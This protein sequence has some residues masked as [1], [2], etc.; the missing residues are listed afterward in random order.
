MRRHFSSIVSHFANFVLFS[1]TLFS[2]FGVFLDNL[3]FRQL[4]GCLFLFM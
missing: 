4:I 1:C 3:A 2:P